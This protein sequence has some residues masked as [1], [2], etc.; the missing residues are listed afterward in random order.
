MDTLGM[1]NECDGVLEAN[2]YCM[3][4]LVRVLDQFDPIGTMD[5]YPIDNITDTIIK[6]NQIQTCLGQS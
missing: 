2:R 4:G 5:K 6:G 3:D 1:S